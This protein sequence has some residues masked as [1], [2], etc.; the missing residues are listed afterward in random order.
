MPEPTH[1]EFTVM[2]IKPDAVEAGKVDEIMEKITESG[3]EILVSKEHHFTKEEAE[4]F[5]KQHA[6]SVCV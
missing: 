5:Y 4:A 6:D 3:I 1:K 2:V